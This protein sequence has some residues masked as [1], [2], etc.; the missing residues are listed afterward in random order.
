MYKNNRCGLPSPVDVSYTVY[1]K[2]FKRKVVILKGMKPLRHELLSPYKK[3]NS[4][5]I[6]N[7]SIRLDIIKLLEKNIGRIF[8]DNKSCNIFCGR[9]QCLKENKTKIKK[10]DL[11]KLK[12][13]HSKGDM[14]K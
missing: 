4:K 13:L 12:N 10:W 11:I 8:F 7:P 14:G 2:G 3:L 6:K 5:W 1:L 9:D